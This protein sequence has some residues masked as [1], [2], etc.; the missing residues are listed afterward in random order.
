MQAYDAEIQAA[1]AKTVWATSCSSWYKRDDGRITV[2]YPYNA[3]TYR[4][5][6]NIFRPGDFILSN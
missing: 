2:L 4:R 5:R 3:Q 6:H 1:L